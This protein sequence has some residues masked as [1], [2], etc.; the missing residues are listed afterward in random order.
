MR[1]CSTRGQVSN[2]SFEEILFNN[3]T[4]NGGMFMPES[5]PNIDVKTLEPWSKLSYVQLCK[6][7]TRLFVSEEE[8][9]TDDLNGIKG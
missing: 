8:I 5:V 7:I 9:P 3:Y 6:V 1:Y 2:K 4:S